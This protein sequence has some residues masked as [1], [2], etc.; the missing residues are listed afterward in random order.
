[1]ITC[2]RCAAVLQNLYVLILVHNTRSFPHP[3]NA[4]HPSGPTGVYN[5]TDASTVGLGTNTASES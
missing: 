5:M 3:V 1:V 2:P 4:P